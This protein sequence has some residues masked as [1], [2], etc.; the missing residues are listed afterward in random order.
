MVES[1]LFDEHLLK[2][3]EFDYCEHYLQELDFYLLFIC[4]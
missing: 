1:I 2:E 3:E 4:P